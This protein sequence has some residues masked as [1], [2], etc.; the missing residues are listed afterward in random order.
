M[1][2]LPA[3]V[4]IRQAAGEA[5]LEGMCRLFASVFEPRS[6]ELA[7]VMFEHYPGPDR[8]VVFIAADTGAAPL[9][10]DSGRAATRVVAAVM[11]V[12][13]PWALEDVVFRVA[14][15]EVVATD[16]A[17]R[18]RGLLRAI[19]GLVDQA[20][21]DGGYPLSAVMGIPSFYDRFGYRFA[22]RS[23]I[24][25]S[26][27]AG[28]VAQA[29]TEDPFF[30]RDRTLTVRS[31]AASDAP[32]LV[33]RWHEQDVGLQ[34]RG[35]YGLDLWEHYLREMASVDMARGQ[36]YVVE[37]GTGR[38]RTV[39]AAFG[40]HL[41][42]GQPM[43]V[44][45]RS[46]DHTA[47]VTA[48]RW[49]A[50]ETL[51]LG[52]PRFLLGLRPGSGD[53]A[54]ALG[55]GARLERPYGWQVKIAE[56]GRFLGAIG[57]ALEKRL[58]ASPFRG[59]TADLVI[60]FFRSRVA[61]RWEKGRLADVVETVGITNLDE[62][63]PRMPEDTFVRLALGYRSLEELRGE[64]IEVGIPRQFRALLEVLFPKL[65]AWVDL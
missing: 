13:R 16:P 32:A 28:E 46:R 22:V 7:R 55:L 43:F 5:D 53:Y 30:E 56:P 48:L 9:P 27:A 11:L 39:V 4:A 57:P 14:H 61:L 44:T 15:V 33:D 51:R 26:M 21:R 19:F 37:E 65:E 52:K 58:A 54:A 17:Y 31:A 10:G 59:L 3:N 29:V 63:R 6:G 45:L 64:Q 35:A 42:G 1:T 62:L 24:S 23:G 49:A 36:W 12:A 18:G 2:H 20:V 60:D 47:A 41:P 8:P 34:L 25:L 40:Y 38:S 50:Q